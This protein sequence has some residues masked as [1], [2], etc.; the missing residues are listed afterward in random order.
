HSSIV[1][2]T[3][4]DAPLEQA[5]CGDANPH[6]VVLLVDPE[7]RPGIYA[8][9]SRFESDL[10]AAGYF[11]FERRSDFA[12]PPEVRA[13]LAD[14]WNRTHQK[15]EGAYLVG[16]FPYVYQFVSEHSDNPGY[17]DVTEETISLQYYADLDGTFATSAG[18]KSRGGHEYSYDL[19]TGEVDWEL[20]IGVLPRAKGPV[21][22]TVDGINRYLDRNHAFRSGELTLPKSFLLVDELLSAGTQAEYDRILAYESSGAYAWTPLSNGPNAHIYFKSA[23]PG[24][25]VSEGYVQLSAGVSDITVLQAHGSYQSSGQIDVDWVTGHYVRTLMIW[26]D[27]CAVGNLDHADNLLSAILYSPTSSVVIAKGTTNNSGGMG[28]NRSGYFGHNIAS[29]IASGG[30]VGEAV[31]GH[32]NVPLIN[33]WAEA[34][35][36]H[37]GTVVLLGDPTIRLRA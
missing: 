21:A 3:V 29:S 27:A 16:S 20:W 28:T 31:L 25:S 2:P 12:T 32:V 6:G 26:S 5:V 24:V 34:R 7:V 19:H 8:R 36:F 30:S 4:P 15:L 18:Y 13:Y 11:V 22:I 33:P 23:Q 1:S 10:C 17:P 35:E 37:F 14:L 9:L